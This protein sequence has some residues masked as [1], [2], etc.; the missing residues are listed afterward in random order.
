MELRGKV[1][2]VTGANGFVGSRVAKRL[3]E[4]GVR[5]R[6]LYRRPEARAEL[7]HLGVEPVPGDILDAGALR[8]AARGTHFVVHAAAV[9]GA[10]ME[11][12]RRI[13]I[14]GTRL[15]LEAAREAG[16]E[17][18]IQISTIAVY[19]A[20]DRERIDEDAPLLTQGEPYSFTKAEADRVVF[21]AIA[22]GL[23]AV[24]LRPA[25]VFGAH[26]TSAWGTR[27]PHAI[28]AGQ[29]PLAHGGKSHMSYVHVDNLADAVVSALRTEAALGQAFN[30]VDGF[31]T[32]RRYADL[33]TSAPLPELPPGQGRHFMASRS[34]LSNEKAQRILGY[35]ARH[36]YEAAVREMLQA[37][38]AESRAG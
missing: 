14:E 2:L 7:E 23:K 32:W 10:S 11:E 28:L 1:A 15:M 36:S 22:H 17:R 24:I 29:F 25:C 33:F 21:D 19:D 6:G 4:E 27:I 9:V 12:A 3:M 20:F 5:V 37:L 34:V 35:T 38:A 26:P 8:A 30:I 13:N 16:S 18:F 31:I